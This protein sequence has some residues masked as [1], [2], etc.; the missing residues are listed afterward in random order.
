[1]CGFCRELSQFFENVDL[2]VL[3]KRFPFHQ[4]RREIIESAR[5]GC[6]LC[7]KITEAMPGASNSIPESMSPELEE[8]SEEDSEEELEM[9]FEKYFDTSF[10]LLFKNEYNITSLELWDQGNQLRPGELLICAFELY[11]SRGM[12]DLSRSLS[13]APPL[14][15]VT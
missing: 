10:F 13:G 15:Q 12:F 6:S 1:M 7:Q 3:E 2:E 9:E 14:T 4:N 8:N 5:G 11:C